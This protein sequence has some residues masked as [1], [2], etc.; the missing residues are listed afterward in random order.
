MSR[1]KTEDRRVNRAVRH[2][3]KVLAADELW[4]GRF[5][6]QQIKKQYVCY[7]DGSHNI[8]YRYRLYDKRTGEIAES[9]WYSVFQI[10]E[11]SCLFWWV[12][13]AIVHTFD[14][15]KYDRNHP[16]NPY[17]IYVDYTKVR[18]F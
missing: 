4:R 2:F 15:W 5:A 12:N 1:H 17:N 7:P 8:Y 14:V 9:E 16:E 11:L 3:N 10:T 13:D 6:L 18:A